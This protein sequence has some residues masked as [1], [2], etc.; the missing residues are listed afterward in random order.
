MRVSTAGMHQSSLNQMMNSQERVNKAMEQ[1]SS[2]KKNLVPSDN[3]IEAHRTQ[4]IK[5]NNKVISAYQL[6]NTKAENTLASVE[7]NLTN[8]SQT[9]RRIKDLTIQATNGTV[10]KEQRDLIAIEV[11]ERLTALKSI[12]NRRDSDGNYMFA[13]FRTD[14]EPYTYNGS[15]YEYHGDAGERSLQVG[16]NSFVPVSVSGYSLFENVK[17]GNGTFVTTDGSVANSGTAMI[18]TGHV[19]DESAFNNETYSISFVTNASAKLAY[20]VTGSVS[21]Q[22]IPVLPGTLPNDA[23][24][25]INGGAIQFAG[26]VVNISGDPKVGDDFAVEPSQPQNLFNTIDR[27]LTAMAMP[28]DTDVQRSAY[29]NV[30][31]RES[32][33]FEQAVNNIGTELTKVGS[34]MNVLQNERV[35]N[36][37]LQT[38]NSKAL[39]ILEDIDVTE[40]ISRLSQEMNALQMAQMSYS[41]IQQLSLLNFL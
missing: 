9:M 1:I 2:G 16:S 32:E 29:L 7:D 15:S 12:A 3:P 13:G 35:I 4:L 40:A 22:L 6:N 37:D 18:S 23:P 25:F 41:K 24:D 28:T 31:D 26:I 36:E 34:N 14:V 21:G 19:I 20:T 33:A 38:Y 8:I 39:T 30:L 11:R 5:N 10:Q 17:N 27:M